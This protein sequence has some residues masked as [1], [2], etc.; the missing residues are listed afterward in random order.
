[1]KT[2]R[3]AISIHASREGS[4]FVSLQ[5]RGVDIDFNPRFPRGKRHP[6][7]PHQCRYP[8]FQSTLPAREATDRLAPLEQPQRISIHASREGSD[9]LR[10]NAFFIYL[11][12]QST[13]PAR[14]ATNILTTCRDFVL[15]FNP[16]FPRG[17]RPNQY[18]GLRPGPAISIHASREGSDDEISII[19]F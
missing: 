15:N 7:R 9:H 1:M 13:L 10:R 19:R 12:F 4:D 2:K 6:P 14:E 5:I 8:K 18:P 3:Y 16:R 17:K 11:V